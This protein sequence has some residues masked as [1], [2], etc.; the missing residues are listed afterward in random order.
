MTSREIAEL[1]GARHDNVKRT[2]ET[3][4][5][6]K[7]I[8]SPQIEEVQTATNKAKVYR[9]NGQQGKRDSIV[10]VARLSPEF[11]ARLVDRWQELEAA[12]Q[13]S[14]LPTIKDPHTA[15][16]IHALTRV[17][18]LEQAQQQQ[19]SRVQKLTE[20]VAVIEARTQL[21]NH[22]FTVLG[23]ANLHGHKIDLNRAATLGKKCANLS[24]LRGLSIGEVR[25]PRFGRVFTYHDSVLEKVFD[26]V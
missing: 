14:A 3:L 1:T 12:Q 13:T 6:Q 22:H 21:E 16:L 4:V 8:E 15:A 5:Q 11:T 23:Y 18:A 9:F 26:S 7:V 24:R 19:L 2:I 17:D 25:D 20:D 10:V